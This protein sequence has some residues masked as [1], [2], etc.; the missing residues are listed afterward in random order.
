M[1]NSANTTTAHYARLLA[2]MAQGG[3]QLSQLNGPPRAVPYQG[4]LE[5]AQMDNLV[6]NSELSSASN[7][8][9]QLSR[10]VPN[11]R[12]NMLIP[13]VMAANLTPNTRA[14]SVVPNPVAN[15]GTSNAPLVVPDDD[16]TIIPDPV[17]S[18]SGKQAF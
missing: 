5:Q 7:M 9:Q 15:L 6:F 16:I 2:Q 10:M 13:N 3:V 12:A 8:M 17:P 18:T 14:P 1:S 4:Q 11:A